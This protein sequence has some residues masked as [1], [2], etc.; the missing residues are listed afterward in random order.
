MLLP[1]TRP[2][3]ILQRQPVLDWPAGSD[4]SVRFRSVHVQDWLTRDEDPRSASS[5]R[6]GQPGTIAA[7]QRIS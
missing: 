1:M 3:S 2:L 5:G 6:D 7:A 4:C